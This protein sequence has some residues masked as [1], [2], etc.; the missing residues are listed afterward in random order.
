[1][2]IKVK[3]LRPGSWYLVVRWKGRKFVKRVADSK[4]SAE[5]IAKELTRELQF[6]GYGALDAFKPKGRGYA[7]TVSGYADRW[8]EELKKSGLK[9]STVESYESNIRLHIKPHFGELPLADV[10]YARV[11]EFISDKLG[12]S[13]S[14]TQKEN[15]ARYSYS[16]DSIRIM[17][18]TLR[19]MLEESVRDELLDSNPVH[20]LG[21]FFGSAKKLREQPDPFS[22]IEL[23]KIE[24]CAGDWLP[25]L[26][27]QSRTGA[28]IGEASALQWRD[29]DF[30]KGQALIR[31]NLPHNR[32]IGTPKSP[33]SVRTVDLSSELLQ[34]LQALYGKQRSFWFKKGSEMP[35]WVFA[36]KQ[37]VPPD[38]NVFRKAFRRL[39]RRA[40][41]RERRV[42]DLRHT[43]AS[44]QLA[45]GKPISY[46]S[47]QLG[48]KNPQITLA[49][50]TRWVPGSEAGER[51]LMD[52]KENKTEDGQVQKDQDGQS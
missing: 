26:L 28:R 41:V 40:R 33:S 39:Q 14:R 31:R 6:R 1:M 44:L 29:I 37:G 50:Y 20:G 36:T 47:A 25:F 34:A 27:F 7:L 30:E 15:A 2:T 3:Q 43:Y 35:E 38:Y 52:R 8:I 49:I 19:A 24:E 4:K 9:P 16:K 22:L 5:E 42:H 10:T 13:Y 11:K 12:G 51:D 18:A 45:A 46:V 17:I 21:K 23:H 48:H 32:I